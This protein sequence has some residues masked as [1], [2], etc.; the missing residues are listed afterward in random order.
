MSPADLA[1]GDGQSIWRNDDEEGGVSAGAAGALP[2]AAPRARGAVRGSGEDADDDEDEGDVADSTPAA[3]LPEDVTPVASTESA[4]AEVGEVDAEVG[5]SDSVVAG[6]AAGGVAAEPPAEELD[7]ASEAGRGEEAPPPPYTGPRI[8]AI[9]QVLVKAC[10]RLSQVAFA[11][12]RLQMDAGLDVVPSEYMR[13][14][15]NYGLL[16]PTYAWA[17][18]VPFAEICNL[19]ECPEGTI[20][21]SGRSGRV[22][23]CT[24]V[25][26]PRFTHSQRTIT[27]L[28]ETCREVRNAA[29]IMGDP[30]LFRKMEVASACIK[31]DVIFAGSLYIQ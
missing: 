1:L 5:F 17:V 11:L 28:E 23:R 25:G 2:P 18:G 4:N 9:P 16:L 12:G 7:A 14:Q 24:L 29:R 19:T 6:G 21:V 26:T 22:G 8:S 10:D 3:A 15:L 13:T 30:V 20:V 27:R 31:R